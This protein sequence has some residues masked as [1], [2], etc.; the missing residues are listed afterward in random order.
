MGKNQQ[1]LPLAE[2]IRNN[3][4]KELW[5]KKTGNTQSDVTLVESR[6]TRTKHMMDRAER[7]MALY[8][9]QRKFEDA[10][11]NYSKR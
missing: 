8:S 1:H 2:Q 5:Q 7:N 10:R 4:V 6:E 9:E 11:A 3:R